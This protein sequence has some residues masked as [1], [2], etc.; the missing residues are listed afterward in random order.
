MSIS[1]NSPSAAGPKLVVGGAAGN[2][3]LTLQACAYYLPHCSAGPSFLRCRHAICD[4]A[5]V[6]NRAIVASFRFLVNGGR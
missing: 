6:W 3:D 2:L 1:R 5:L 4:G